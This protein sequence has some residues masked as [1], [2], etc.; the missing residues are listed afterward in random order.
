M[1]YKNT[2]YG[3][4]YNKKMYF[5]YKEKMISLISIHELNNT[6]S[7]KKSSIKKPISKHTEGDII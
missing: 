6:F 4:K 3:H 2:F 7:K 5:Y 1:I